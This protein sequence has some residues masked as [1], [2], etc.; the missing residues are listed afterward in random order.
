MGAVRVVAPL[1][2]GT[3]GVP[4]LPGQ[5]RCGSKLAALCPLEAWLRPLPLA[6]CSSAVGFAGMPA[7]HAMQ[8][9][10]RQRV[11]GAL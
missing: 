10:L 7:Q 8:A 1:Q 4:G 6:A 3:R 9:V 2:C 5:S 11:P